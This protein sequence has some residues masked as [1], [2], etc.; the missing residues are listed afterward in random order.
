MGVEDVSIDMLL[1]PINPAD[2]NQM[3]GYILC[4]FSDSD[5]ISVTNCYDHQYCNCFIPNSCKCCAT[6][7]FKSIFHTVFPHLLTVIF[8]NGNVAFDIVYVFH[9]L[10]IPV[11]SL[12]VKIM[13]C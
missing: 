5:L 3:Q 4:L 13:Y 12:D 8:I 7:G 11:C 2:V 10:T 1:C 6:T 9:V